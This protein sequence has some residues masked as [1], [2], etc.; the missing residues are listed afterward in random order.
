MNKPMADS[1]EKVPNQTNRERDTT[2]Q[3]VISN[4]RVK[5]SALSR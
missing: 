2:M 5:K 4:M 3:A 1:V